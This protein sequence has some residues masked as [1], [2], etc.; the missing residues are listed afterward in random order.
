M[1]IAVQEAHRAI[2]AFG[3]VLFRYVYI[4]DPWSWWPR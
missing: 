1:L 4:E 2:F 3:M